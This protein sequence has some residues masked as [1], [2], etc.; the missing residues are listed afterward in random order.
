MQKTYP[1]KIKA[2][3]TEG[4]LA[5][6]QFRAL[7]S[8]F[9]N[10]DAYGDVVVPGAFKDTLEEWSA[11]GDSIPVYWSHQ[12]HDPD[13]NIG[14]VVEAKETDEGL[15]VLAQVDLEDDASPKAKQAYRLLKGRRVREFSFAYDVVDGGPVEKDGDSYN[16]LRTL[17]LYEV[18]P[19][20]IGANPATELIGVKYLEAQVKAGRV[21]SAKNEDALRE[22]VASLEASAKSIK[23]VLAAVE[24]NDDDDSKAGAPAPNTSTTAASEPG[25]AKDEEPPTG[26]KSEE[27]SRSASSAST[28]AAHIAIA[29]RKELL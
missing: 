3:G 9:G 21:L 23:N 1:A 7:V 11:S 10:K 27:P 17:K 12:M 29:S 6:G 28:W 16:E 2:T 8:V 18:G 19:T 24:S 26:A 4:G 14:Y 20:P 15:E 25:P 13:F 22:A 5:E